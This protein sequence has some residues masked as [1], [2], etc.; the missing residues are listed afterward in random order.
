M[1]KH[2]RGCVFTFTPDKRGIR[3]TLP[4]QTPAKIAIYNK[5]GTKLMKAVRYVAPMVLDLSDLKSGTYQMVIN[6][7]DATAV[8]NIGFLRMI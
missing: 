4:D 1:P 6:Y 3:L 5:K 8:K 2:W 7:G